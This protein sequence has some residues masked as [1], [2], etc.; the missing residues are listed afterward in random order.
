MCLFD[1]VNVRLFDAVNVM[2]P[3]QQESRGRFEF[4]KVV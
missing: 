2:H 1:T 3:Q 4:S